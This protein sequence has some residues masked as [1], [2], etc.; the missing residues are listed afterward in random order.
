M[1][2]RGFTLIEV[3]VALVLVSIMALLAWRG[4]ESMSVVTSQTSDHERSTQLLVTTLAQWRADLDAMVDTGTV[5]AL[6]FDGKTLRLTRQSH[7]M[8]DG[9]IVVAWRIQN[10]HLERYAAP[11]VQDQTSLQAAWLLAERW[12]R[13]P[14]AEDAARTARLMPT[15]AWQLFYYRGDAWTNPQS[16]GA[17]GDTS[18][19]EV[20]KIALPD[21]VRLILEIPEGQ[22]LA[23]K[24]T[25][26]W[27]APTLGATR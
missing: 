17:V 1:K 22:I 15:T 20:A 23:G 10:G 3:L 5:Q 16:S 7:P 13:T 19:R 9:I 11:A 18:G 21:G 27:I 25:K 26:D 12:G 24:V 14:L 8:A 2:Q 4:V 6:D